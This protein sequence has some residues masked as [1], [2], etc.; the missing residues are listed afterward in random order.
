M[1][2]LPPAI[3]AAFL[4]L[5]L[6]LTGCTGIDTIPATDDAGVISGSQAPP[7]TAAGDTAQSDSFDFT[8][9]DRDKDA[10]YDALTA[11]PLIFS[12]ANQTETITEEGTYL[13]SGSSDNGQLIVDLT[14]AADPENSKVH[15]V[16]D[17]VT[18]TNTAAPAVVVTQADKVFITLADGSVN[19]LS[20]GS[21]RTDLAADDAANDDTADNADENATLYSHDDLSINGTGALNVSSTSHHAIKCQD[22]LVI[23]DGTILITSGKDGLR[24]KDAVKIAG[25]TITVQA[26]DDG[27][28]SSQTD[29]PY[30]KGF[31]SITGGEITIN[32]EGDGI[33]AEALVR[34]A[35]GSVNV[36]S[37][38]E[39]IEG[40]LVWLEGGLHSLTAF[41]D[42]IN[43]AGDIRTDYLINITG[44]TYSINAEGDGVDSNSTLTQS[45]GT[46][47]VAGP[48]QGQ[49]EGSL[50]AEYSATITGGTMVALDNAAMPA[51]Y[52][53]DSTQST[54]LYSADSVQAA[55]T[56]ITLVDSSST[57]I[58][59]LVAP[60]DFRNIAFSSPQLKEG[61]SYSFVLGGDVSGGLV[62]TDQASAPTNPGYGY[63]EGGT[64]NGGDT[65]TT[66]TMSE[67]IAQVSSDGSV[68]AYRGG[69]MGGWGGPGDG[70]IPNGDMSGG[71]GGQAPGGDRGGSQAPGSREGGQVPDD[72]GGSQG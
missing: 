68:S 30:E 7:P 13:V 1:G 33:K 38:N 64:L 37:S 31:V 35:G 8:V 61:E 65:L 39:G 66:F 25:G 21:G 17:G 53:T 54:L 27:I 3:L 4:V 12:S 43:A 5:S 45:G 58:F 62:T 24:G 71:P 42:G 56:R 41:D 15:L 69:M 55:D 28:F 2:K 48:S 51:T 67:Q 32:A 70:Q 57:V 29:A 52:G 9:T 14:T 16:F 18:L 34:L 11:T 63:I 40:C 19:T 49:A 60:K 26:G 47:V 36:E 10:S 23:A 72:R 20:D 6:A 46:V 59:S 50:D 22:N 44:G